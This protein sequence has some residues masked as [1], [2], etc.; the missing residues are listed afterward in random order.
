MRTITM[1]QLVY[2]IN[3]HLRHECRVRKPYFW[4]RGLVRGLGAYCAETKVIGWPDGEDVEYDPKD[5]DVVRMAMDLGILGPDEIIEPPG[6]RAV[7]PDTL[8]SRINRALGPGG[9]WLRQSGGEYYVGGGA[10]NGDNV[11]IAALAQE[12]GVLYPG[13]FVG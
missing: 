3:S 10:Y 2:R 12:L 9:G 13:E 6:R 7:H 4:E 1:D 8:R 5:V 11:D